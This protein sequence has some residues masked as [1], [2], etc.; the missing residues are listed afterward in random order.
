MV[1]FFIATAQALSLAA[2]LYGAYL[3]LLRGPQLARTPD[4]RTEV[5]A[6]DARDAVERDRD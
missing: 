5:A 2:L 3:V 6:D 1:E 4:R